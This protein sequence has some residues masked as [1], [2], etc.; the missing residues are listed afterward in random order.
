MAVLQ[1]NQQQ[2]SRHAD[3]VNK[4]IP[5]CFSQTEIQRF[6]LVDTFDLQVGEHME[7]EIHEGQEKRQRM[8][9]HPERST[10]DHRSDTDTQI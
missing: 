10:E 3:S 7:D 2:S 5:R 9:V 4:D 6:S 1:L 8:T